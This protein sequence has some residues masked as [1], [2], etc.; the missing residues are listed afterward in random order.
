[1]YAKESKCIFASN[2]VEYLGH[3]ISEK[4]VETDPSKIAVVYSW[5]VP[6]TIKDLRSFFG[7]NGIL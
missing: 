1:M 7:F 2:K 3:F 4:G 6:S 5:P